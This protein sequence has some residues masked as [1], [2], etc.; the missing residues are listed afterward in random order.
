MFLLE[1]KLWLILQPTGT[2][3]WSN[4]MIIWWNIMRLTPRLTTWV[5]GFLDT[6]SKWKRRHGQ[7]SQDI[8]IW[9]V[10]NTSKKIALLE[11][12]VYAMFTA[13][14]YTIAKRWNQPKSLLRDEQINK[15]AIKRK[16]TLIPPNSKSTTWMNETLSPPHEWIMKI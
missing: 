6:Y 12:Y 2:M 7:G 16:E 10:K 5:S 1:Y 3:I 15:T 11:R 13:A 14:L 4:V 9:P 8:L